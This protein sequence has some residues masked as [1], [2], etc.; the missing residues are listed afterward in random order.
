M[1][2]QLSQNQTESDEKIKK[3]TSN[4]RELN[5]KNQEL[6]KEIKQ[7]NKVNR[8]IRILLHQK[9]LIIRFYF[10]KILKG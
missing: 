7:L 10:F 6:N 5:K 3:L 9:A 8:S 2:N 1:N 4:Y